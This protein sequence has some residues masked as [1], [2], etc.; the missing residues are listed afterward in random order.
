MQAQDLKLLGNAASGVFLFSGN[1]NAV[2]NYF[3]IG[4]GNGLPGS[5][6]ILVRS[7]S[8]DL[9]KDNQISETAGG[10]DSTSSGC[11]IIHN[12]VAN[13]FRGLDLSTSD[14][15]QGNVATGCHF[16]F[17]GG[18]AIGAENGGN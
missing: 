14:Y 5:F 15:Y 11:A 18:N 16:A 4:P 13:S 17:T 2:V 1:D 3:I 9:V 7:G 12:Y 8:G 6:G 10:I